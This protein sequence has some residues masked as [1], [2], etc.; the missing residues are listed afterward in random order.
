VASLAARRAPTQELMTWRVPA[1]ITPKTHFTRNTSIYVGM[2]WPHLQHGSA[3]NVGRL[4]SV[5]CLTILAEVGDYSCILSAQQFI[6]VPDGTLRR[7]GPPFVLKG[8]CPIG[9]CGNNDQR[10]GQT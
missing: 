7:G 6:V 4:F 10:P 8:G 1:A 3:G 5:K 9:G 2:G